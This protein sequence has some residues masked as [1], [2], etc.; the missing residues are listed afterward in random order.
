MFALL[1]SNQE[2]T[3]IFV[4]ASAEATLQGAERMRFN[5]FT[6]TIVRIYEN[7]FLQ[8]RAGVIDP[9]HWE[10]MARMIV[11]VSSM[12]ASKTYWLDRKHRASDEFQQY[13]DTNVISA[14]RQTGGSLPGDY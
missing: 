2:L 13:M 10:G 6:H 12:A 1:T 4:T 5:T 11:D 3:E 14:P 9:A 7:A 8:W